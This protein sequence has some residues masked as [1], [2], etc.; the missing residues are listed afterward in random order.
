MITPVPKF[1]STASS[2]ITFNLNFPIPELG[3]CGSYDECKTYCDDSTR[4]NAC[5]SF[6]EKNGLVKKEEAGAAKEILEKTFDREITFFRAPTLQRPSDLLD[7]LEETGYKYDSSIID[8]QREQ[9]Y[10]GKGNSFFLPFYPIINNKKSNIL[11]EGQM[12][13]MPAKVPHAVNALKR[14]KMVLILIKP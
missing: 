1:I 14:F 8:S 13:L 6:A 9:P 11:A 10:C 5:F 3:N 7:S 4:A 2:A 12:I